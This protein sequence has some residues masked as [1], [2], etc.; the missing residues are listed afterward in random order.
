M[1]ENNFRERRRKSIQLEKSKLREA[2]T[3]LTN[4]R[5]DGNELATKHHRESLQV[6]KAKLQEARNY[7]NKYRTDGGEPDAKA[8]MPQ[9]AKNY[10]SA[11]DS[12]ESKAPDAPI[13]IYTHADD[14]VAPKRLFIP[15][16]NEEENRA[17]EALEHLDE[18]EMPFVGTETDEIEDSQSIYSVDTKTSLMELPPSPVVQ[19]EED[20]NPSVLTN[21]E[22]TIESKDEIQLPCND[23]EI[24]VAGDQVE[25]NFNVSVTTIDKATIESNDEIQPPCNDVEIA[26]TSVQEEE[27]CNP[28]VTTNDKTTIETNDEIQ[29]LSN[30]IELK[31][32]FDPYYDD[33]VDGINAGNDKKEKDCFSC[34]FW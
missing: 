29:L 24:D 17:E 25:A 18:Q 15:N 11:P 19:E 5:A 16:D 20:Y 31:A 28:S 27:D 1:K 9:V 3:Y 12:T 30:A 33:N 10:H 4:Y 2:K 32:A 8:K 13:N 14:D 7:L 21:D 26:V 6:E 23:V 34:V 22:N